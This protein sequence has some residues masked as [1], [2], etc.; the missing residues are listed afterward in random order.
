M[1]RFLKAMYVTLQYYILIVNVLNYEEIRIDI[2]NYISILFYY[3]V[4]N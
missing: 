4:S 3:A 2:A 1:N